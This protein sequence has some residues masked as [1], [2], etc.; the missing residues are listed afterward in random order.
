MPPFL[1]D[2][3]LTA[4]EIL[5]VLNNVH[6]FYNQAWANWSGRL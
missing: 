2:T 3:V 6:E 1:A 5:D 4:P